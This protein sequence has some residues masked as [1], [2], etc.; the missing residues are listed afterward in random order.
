ME[1]DL[2]NIF[3]SI[4]LSLY[5][6]Y[7]LFAW[8]KICIQ[9]DWLQQYYSEKVVAVWN[10]IS[11]FIEKPEKQDNWKIEFKLNERNK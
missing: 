9:F 8:Y 10:T 6:K 7:I 4:S 5:S 11:S 1:N 3:Y 2:L